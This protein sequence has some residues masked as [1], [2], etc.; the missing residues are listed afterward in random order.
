MGF[1]VRKLDVKVLTAA[2]LGVC[3]P[4]TDC[5]CGVPSSLDGSGVVGRLFCELKFGLNSDVREGE[6]G[7][8]VGGRL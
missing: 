4:D 6:G 2:E 8:G 3:A 7:R 5:V 1:A